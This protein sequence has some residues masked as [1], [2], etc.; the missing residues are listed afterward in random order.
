I[1]PSIAGRGG[2]GGGT[3][4]DFGV[5]DLLGVA[6]AGSYTAARRTYEQQIARLNDFFDDA[7]KYQKAR[8][9]NPPGFV[10][11]LKFEAMIPVLERK[12]PVAV[13]AGRT[14]TIHDAI[15]FSEKQN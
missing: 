3:P 10:R 13:S 12:M 4:P 11:D 6:G 2:R 1:F 14:S 7:R 9:A 5:P 15:A 8:A